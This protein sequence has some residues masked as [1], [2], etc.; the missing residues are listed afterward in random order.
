MTTLAVEPFGLSRAIPVEQPKA[1]TWPGPLSYSPEKQ[2][3]VVE[4]TGVPFIDTPSMASE[5]QTVTQTREDSQLFD[6]DG[7]TDTD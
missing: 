4:E 5:I 3:T 6:D 7:G 2:L 1:R